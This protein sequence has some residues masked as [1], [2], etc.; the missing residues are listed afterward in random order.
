MVEELDAGMNDIGLGPG[1][2][3]AACDLVFLAGLED[4]SGVE[5]LLGRLTY[6]VSVLLSQSCRDLDDE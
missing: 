3:S 2:L 1:N 5:K 4:G 6:G